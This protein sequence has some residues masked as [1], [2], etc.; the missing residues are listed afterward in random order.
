MD[1]ISAKCVD[2]R[3]EFTKKDLE[4]ATT[5]CPSC[6]STCVPMS[7]DNDVEI[8]INWH[9]LRILFMWAERWADHVKQKE[10]GP[11]FLQTIYAIAKEVQEQH[12]SKDPITL[13]GEVEELKTMFDGV[14]TSNIPEGGPPKTKLH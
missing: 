6:G 1:K 8:K 11:D 10:E 12:P 5:Q 9:E 3:S 2:C 7:P 13:S 4:G 14:E